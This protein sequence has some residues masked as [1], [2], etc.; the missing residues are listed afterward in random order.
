MLKLQM[1][2]SLSGGLAIA[3][4]TMMTPPAAA[5]TP[6]RISCQTTVALGQGAQLT[7]RVMGTVPQTTKT[8]TPQN[9]IG[10]SLSITVQRRDQ[11]GRVQTLIERAA[12]SEYA[13]MAPDADYSRL[14]FD[15]V[16]RGQPN[17]G[18]RL[19]AAPA[20]TH[21]LYVSLRP[22]TGQ[23]RQIQTLHSLRPGQYLRSTVGTC[24]TE[25]SNLNGGMTQQLAA[26]QARLQAKDWAAADRETRRLLAPDS[27]SLPPFQP[28]SVSP[29]LIRAIDQ[30]W[31]RASDGRFG[32]SV[33]ARLWQ[34]ARAA[35]PNNNEAAV[36]AFRDRVGWKLKTPRAEEDFISSDW[37]NEA[38]LT[39]TLQAPKGHLPWVGVS[40]DVVQAIAVP[41]PGVHCGSCT[42]DA[43]QLRNDRFYRY[44]PQLM[45]RVQAALN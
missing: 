42:V 21:G 19:Y 45:Q 28:T 9:P 44:L 18:D 34:A 43:I 5:Q 8:A 20:S 35:H 25:T 38:E 4:V 27:V 26:L 11:N 13:Q 16:F 6:Y 41:P 2:K 30:M 24:Q 1:L 36:N 10:N 22:T 7:Y 14:P 33:Q 12:L 37:L 29:P 40:D 23:P 31:L 3:L 39:Y 17:R 32:L 15:P